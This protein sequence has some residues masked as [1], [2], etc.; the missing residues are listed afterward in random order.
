MSARKNKFNCIASLF[1]CAS[2]IKNHSYMAK[3]PLVSLDATAN[4]KRYHHVACVYPQ[5]QRIQ[6]KLSPDT[7]PDCDCCGSN[8]RKNALARRTL[9]GLCCS[10]Q[11]SVLSRNRVSVYV[12][13]IVVT[14]TGA[15]CVID[16]AICPCYS[17]PKKVISS[18]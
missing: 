3:L 18:A 6:T 13:V 11:K 2:G 8:K 15:I 5:H 17:F 14:T 1:S 7:K 16:L 12:I 4:E 10:W 9:R